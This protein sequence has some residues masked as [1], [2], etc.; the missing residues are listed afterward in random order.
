V[1]SDPGLSNMQFQTTELLSTTFLTLAHVE[2][3]AALS[4]TRESREVALRGRYRKWKIRNAHGLVRNVMWY[5]NIDIVD[6]L[7]SDSPLSIIGIA[8]S[9]LRIFEKQYPDEI[10]EVRY[11]AVSTRLWDPTSHHDIN[12]VWPLIDFM[13]LRELLVVSDIDH[14]RTC[15]A[16]IMTM[17]AGSRPRPWLIPE[18]LE[19]KMDVLRAHY[20]AYGPEYHPL[21]RKPSVRVT[22]DW[23]GILNGDEMHIILRDLGRT[24]LGYQ[25]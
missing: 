8:V 18:D 16:I 11:L 19:D 1:P 14:E 24:Y 9:P 25:L 12:V 17:S 10:K 6:F 22:K 21:P 7:E 2:T 3:V 23:Q 15:L 4:T 13:S 20:E 5:P